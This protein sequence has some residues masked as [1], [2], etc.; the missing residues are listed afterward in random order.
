MEND[1]GSQLYRAGM[2]AASVSSTD[3]LIDLPD[4]I[5]YLILSLLDTKTVVQTTVL[6]RHWRCV[7]KQIPVLKFKFGDFKLDT[8]S[9]DDSYE[10]F[11][12]FV[13]GVLS[14]H[15]ATN[16]DTIIYS[17]PMIRLYREENAQDEEQDRVVKVVEFAVSHHTRHLVL[18][19]RSNLEDDCYRFPPSFGS[20][21]DCNL[22]SLDLKF[23]SVDDRFQSFGFR[24]LTT[25]TLGSCI[26][27]SERGLIDPFSKF[28][29][30]KS[31]SIFGG[32]MK[33]Y[34]YGN[35]LKKLRI[36]GVQLR[37]L[38]L[39]HMG[40][41]DVEICAPKLE[42]FT[43]VHV[44][45]PMQFS[46]LEFSALDHAEIRIY[47]FCGVKKENMVLMLQAFHNVKSLTLGS[48]V[49]EILCQDFQFLK[50]QPS[51]FTRLETLNLG[52]RA[53]TR[54]KPPPRS[55]TKINTDA[56]RCSSRN[57][58]S[59]AWIVR[60]DQGRVL[61]SCSSLYNG[62]TDIATL[63]ALGIRDAVLWASYHNFGHVIFESDCLER[64]RR[65]QLG[66]AGKRLDRL[67][68][69]PDF[70][71]YSILSLLDTKSVVQTSVLSR[72]WRCVWKHV[73]ALD[74]DV[75]SF[76]YYYEGF[77]VF[78]EKVLSLHYPTN[79]DT[80]R[81]CSAA[82]EQVEQE[83]ETDPS[84]TKILEFA[85]S[86][87]TRHLALQVTAESSDDCYRFPRSYY[88]SSSISNSILETVDLRGFVVNDRFAFL[89]FGL[90]KTLKL[91]SCMFESDHELIDPFSK[92][93]CLKSLSICSSI[94][95]YLF[96]DEPE[97]KRL[98]IVGVKLDSLEL[99]DTGFRDVE[100]CAPK[101]KSFT[102]VDDAIPLK[103]SQL[104]FPSLDRADISINGFGGRFHNDKKRNLVL[105]LQ[106]FRN[107]KAMTLR[108]Q[109]IEVLCEDFELLEQQR[110]SFTR[111]ETLNM[112]L[113]MKKYNDIPYKLRS[114]S[115]AM[116]EEQSYNRAGK[117]LCRHPSTD[118]LSNLP[119]AVLLHILSL[120]KTK[121][122][123]QTSVMSRRWRFVWQNVPVLEFDVSD[124]DDSFKRFNVFV[125]KVLSLRSDIQ[126]DIERISYADGQ[127]HA[128]EDEDEDKDKDRLE[129]RRDA[130]VVR[131]IELAASHGTRDLELAPNCLYRFPQS[132][133]C[134]SGSSIKSLHLKYCAIDDRLESFGFQLLTS[135]ELVACRFESDQEVMDPFSKFPCL[136]SLSMFGCYYIKIKMKRLR[137]AGVELNSLKLNSTQ[138]HKYDIEICAPNLKTF[139]LD[140]D[141][142][143]GRIPVLLFSRPTFASLDHAEIRITKFVRVAKEDVVLMLQ[144]FRNV[145]SLTV[146]IGIIEVISNKEDF[147]FL[148]QQSSPF[149]RLESLKME[150]PEYFEDD[151]PPELESYFVRGSTCASP[152]VKNVFVEME[153]NRAQMRRLYSS[154]AS[155]S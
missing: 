26:F 72:R 24:L 79:V 106:A 87:G 54:W 81:Y 13:D 128:D 41:A 21:P 3:R 38:K 92:L 35:G 27:E 102:L 142:L 31:L 126:N 109:V 100:V 48:R 132:Y 114:K 73:P 34:F 131:L 115:R 32:C 111:L 76:D 57:V 136:K 29:C 121:T 146:G 133:G 134:I 36:A 74:L 144:A 66:T 63:E 151:V 117:R 122:V 155:Y 89:G 6:S 7:W 110:S 67:S 129:E 103:V 82:F 140:E 11:H 154:M 55:W 59:T 8:R 85:V 105:M 130:L 97:A 47:G 125:D 113:P 78:V 139:I 12:A 90:L 138:F 75:S 91:S 9:Y 127:G 116:A 15:Y 141:R 135:L 62:I 101:L 107:V 60:N 147:K 153:L 148:D 39:E 20:I 22:E 71:L 77:Y 123:V 1:R 56:S 80:I 18:H 70:I 37:S 44:Q 52:S 69:L 53:S 104:A 98:R 49:I 42:S 17:S 118:R 108:S 93:A 83:A 150:L 68:H 99:H 124:F 137:I 112:E 40:F 25:L 43:L 120:M 143:K 86:H 152:K 28:P 64:K 61:F 4:F 23:C 16:V 51:P 94:R 2:R 84:V 95:H 96:R 14:L 145:R 88:G 58:G 46:Q 10:R 50:Q 65:S 30:L 45:T 149:T 33:N 5:L 19:L 119:Q